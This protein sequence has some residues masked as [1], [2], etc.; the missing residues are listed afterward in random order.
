[1]KRREF[2]AAAAAFVGAADASRLWAQ[3]A[4][5]AGRAKQSTLDRIAIMTLNFQRLL[6]LPDLPQEPERTLELFD[7]PE[8]LA[9]KYGVH[10]IEFQHY[11]I[12]STEPSFLKELRAQIEKRKSRM[13]QINLEFGQLNMSAPELRNRLMAI[14]LTKMWVDHAVM[15]GAQRVMINQGQPTQENKSY[16]IPTLKTMADYGRS[17]GIIVSVETRGGGGGRGRGTATEATAP[18]PPPPPPG[19]V[20]WTLLAEIIKGAGAYSN[21]DVGG[22]NAANQE[23]LHN[24]LRTMFPMM[25]GSMHTRVNTR[26]D[27][28]TAIR[29]LEGELGYTGLYTI[30]A[31]NGHEGT[32]Q[33]YDVVVATL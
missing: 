2:L 15:L 5:P 30:E 31:S 7:V 14:D 23:E 8:M 19:P 18:A 11:H 21:V 29:F 6:K 20:V 33:I 12:P 3:S 9:D 1:M 13:T 32:Q 28:A 22:A 26:W 10:K 17:K 4:S 16:G 24:C 25:A 27:L